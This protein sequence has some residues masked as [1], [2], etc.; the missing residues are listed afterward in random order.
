M[1]LCIK[2]GNF[3]PPKPSAVAA[4]LN[5]TQKA[6]HENS[7]GFNI[8]M[9]PLFCPYPEIDQRKALDIFSFTSLAYPISI[10]PIMYG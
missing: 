1:K 3:T 2:S 5:L 7:P 8:F 6:F 4:V 9:S 10:S